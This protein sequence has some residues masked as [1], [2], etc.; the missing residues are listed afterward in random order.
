MPSF[1]CRDCGRYLSTGLSPVKEK[2]ENCEPAWIQ[3]ELKEFERW[4][5][6]EIEEV[7][8]VLK[9]RDE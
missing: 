3:E 7:K 1:Y 2:C 4:K 8:E 5:S 9:K 6:Q